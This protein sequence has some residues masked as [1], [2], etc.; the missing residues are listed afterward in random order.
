VRDVENAFGQPQSVV[1]LGGSSDIAR[2][3][4]R[5]L[6]ASRARIVILAG[7][8][9]RLLDEARD[10][11]LARGATSVDTVLFDA[12]DPSNAERVVDES[13]E[14]AGGVVDLVVLAVG[15][16]GDQGQFEDDATLAGEMATVNFTWPVAALARVRGLLVAQGSGRILVISS[17][18]AVRVRRAKYLYGGAKAGLDR[19]CLG[20]A[21]SLEGTGV[22]LQIVR[23]GHVRSKMTA[24]MK[25]PPFATGTEDV[26]NDVMKGFADRRAVIWSP[27]I[28][29][30]VFFALRHLPAPLW[31]KV[32]DEADR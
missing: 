13:F 23:P 7:R 16:L 6:C 15:L 30:Y 12:L 5:R 27:P 1:V 32:T 31:R 29:R 10:E 19:L 24:G 28:L 26:A 18:A 11:A 2:A 20:L 4:T 22:T 8:S 14:K 21:D 17:V 9:Q 25:D 3:L